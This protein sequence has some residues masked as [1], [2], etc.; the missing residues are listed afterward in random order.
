MMRVSL[1]LICLK[2]LVQN[3]TTVAQLFQTV[4]HVIKTKPIAN[5]RNGYCVFVMFFKIKSI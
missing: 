1:I 3:L 5:L 2:E 4:A